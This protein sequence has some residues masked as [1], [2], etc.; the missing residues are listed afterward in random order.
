MQYDANGSLQ[1]N[2]RGSDASIVGAYAPNGARNIVIVSTDLAPAPV[3][4]VPTNGTLLTAASAG[5]VTT[6]EKLF[7]V[8]IPGG[9]LGTKGVITFKAFWS[10]TNSANQKNLRVR[11]GT[12]DDLNGTQYFNY[13]ATTSASVVTLMD[14]VNR[15]SQ[16][17]QL[18]GPTS[19]SSGLGNTSGALITGTVNTANDSYLVFSGQKA[20]AGETITLEWAQVYLRYVA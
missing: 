5:A 12:A 9:S 17:S 1:V 10:Y 11:H 7:S 3:A 4:T 18:G 19:L 6:E 14:I 2:L 16:S 15:N 8:L 13:A 20:N